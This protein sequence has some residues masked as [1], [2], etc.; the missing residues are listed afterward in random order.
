[1]EEFL[2]FATTLAGQAGVTFLSLEAFVA[3]EGGDFQDLFH[4][5]KRAGRRLTRQF[6]EWLSARGHA[7]LL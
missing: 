1:M 3:Y 4:L 5:N 7:P 6:V 2:D